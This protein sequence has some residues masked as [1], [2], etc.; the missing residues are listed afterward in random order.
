MELSHKWYLWFHSFESID[1]TVNGYEKIIEICNI[2]HL[3]FVLKNIDFTSGLYFLMKENKIPIWEEN[4]EDYSYTYRK[5]IN[6][7]IEIY[8]KVVIYFLCSINYE[9]IYGISFSP[10]TKNGII[11]LWCNNIINP[12]DVSQKILNINEWQKKLN[13]DK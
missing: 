9:N 3:W 2:D 13:K 10:K 12:N 5:S 6:D 4:V 7:A 8:K 1:W 11:K